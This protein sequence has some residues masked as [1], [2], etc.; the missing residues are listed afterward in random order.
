MFMGPLEASKP[1]NTQSVDGVRRFL[2]RIWRLYVEEDGGPSAALIGDPPGDASRVLH[3]TIRKVTEDI[4][5]L[6]F[7]TAIAQMMI[8]VNEATKLEKR[9]RALLEPFILLLAPFAPHLAEELWSRLGH[10][11]SLAYAPWPSWDPALVVEDSVTVAVQVNGKLRTTIELPRGASREDARRA[12]EA[13]EKVRR[14]LDESEIRKVI[15]VPEKLVNFVVTEKS[16]AG[17]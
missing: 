16:R 17:A 7:N 1:W 10:G 3:Q 2:D 13:D 5:G 9:S 14:Y 6:R 12:A 11:E 8:F 4:E 15:V